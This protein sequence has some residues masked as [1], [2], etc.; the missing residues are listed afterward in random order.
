MRSGTSAITA[1]RS[2]QSAGSPV[3]TISG[4]VF[5][6]GSGAA[7]VRRPQPRTIETLTAVA[8]PTAASARPAI[9]A[10]RLLMVKRRRRRPARSVNRR[11]AS[12]GHQS[13]RVE[14][15]MV[16]ARHAS[17]TTSSS[18]VRLRSITGGS[19]SG[20]AVS[21]QRG[22]SPKTISYITTPSAQTSD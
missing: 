9:R 15:W 16:Q 3:G 18:A 5:P 1:D 22:F 6:A 11:A 19:S 10:V 13:L 2:V 7:S 20:V 21:R 8:A 14:S 12:I 17:S 4:D